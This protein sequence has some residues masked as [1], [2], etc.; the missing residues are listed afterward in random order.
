MGRRNDF[1][2][3]IWQSSKILGRTIRNPRA[4]EAQGLVFGGVE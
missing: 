2:S 4:V 3:I 1:N